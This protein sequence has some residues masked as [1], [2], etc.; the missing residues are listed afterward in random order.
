[1]RTGSFAASLL[2]AALLLAAS[3]AHALWP[4][5]DS[6]ATKAAALESKGNTQLQAADEAWRIGDLSKA[7]GLYQMAAETY[8][9]AEQM[10]PDSI[11][12]SRVSGFRTALA[13]SNRSITRARRSRRLRNA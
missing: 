5:G 4:F 2:T 13:R 8:R 10:S 3:H 6:Q 12:A 11:M 1:M 9:G 7:S